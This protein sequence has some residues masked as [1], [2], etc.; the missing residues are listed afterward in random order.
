VEKVGIMIY[1]FGDLGH[2][3]F[4]TRKNLNVAF[5]QEIFETF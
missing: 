3:I 2:F 1:S 5:L 4:F